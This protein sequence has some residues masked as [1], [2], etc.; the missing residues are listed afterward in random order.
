MY[1]ENPQFFHALWLVPLIIGLLV[2]A[3]IRRQQ[4]LRQFVDEPMLDRLMPGSDLGWA[5]AKGALLV[6]AV[7]CLIFA[8]ARP[9]WGA[10]MEPVSGRGADLFVLLDV[11]RSMLVEDVAPNR[12]ERAKSDILDLLEE[13]QG[14]RVGLIT[15]AGAAVL[16]IPLTTDQGFFRMALAEVDTD[17][18]PIGGS[19]IGDAVRKA[20]ASMEE[21]RD[22]DQV[23]VLIT[24][25][26]DHDSFP[27][28]AA[29]QAAERK[30]K[31]IAIG[32]GDTNEGGRIPERDES[33]R[34][35]YAKEEDGRE[36]WSKMD[37]R[38]LKEMALV[39]GG[40]YV[41]AKSQAY[42][43]G[44]LYREHLA[45][46][47]RGEIHAEKRKRYRERFQVFLVAGLLLLGVETVLP[48]FTGS[49]K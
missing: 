3:S 34:L 15:F 25:G 21:R 49:R 19:H 39:T 12:L 29:E 47:S 16:K 23:L 26:E 33:G 13:L 48:R 18:A 2:Y 44:E 35:R 5:I 28:E 20:L 41:P 27:K 14:D 24:D 36:H 8:A 9:R 30:V 10:Y 37:E 1:W 40:A 22:R 46:L 6:L 17:S 4:A 45:D 11:S 43:L 38:L 42:D 32:L 7:V 31:I